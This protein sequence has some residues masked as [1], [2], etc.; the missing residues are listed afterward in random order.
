MMGK[1]QGR[2]TDGASTTNNNV[3]KDINFH[4]SLV[5][6]EVKERN[7]T[8]DGSLCNFTFTINLSNICIFTWDT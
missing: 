6:Y 7:W 1:Y 2:L 3:K 5:V 4:V 8:Q